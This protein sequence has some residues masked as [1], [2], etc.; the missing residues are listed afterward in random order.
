MSDVSRAEFERLRDQMIGLIGT[1]AMPGGKLGELKRDIS[2]L[3]EALSQTPDKV[4][5]ALDA[6]KA[7]SR[8]QLVRDLTGLVIGVVVLVAA[9]LI[10]AHFNVP[11]KP[12]GP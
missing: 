2:D 3:K 8:K 4:L 10:L 12:H 7:S 9:A 1:D 6:R 5:A 11:Q